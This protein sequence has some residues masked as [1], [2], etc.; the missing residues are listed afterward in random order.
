MPR[1][2]ASKVIE[3]TAAQARKAIAKID[4]QIEELGREIERLARARNAHGALIFTLEGQAALAR[5]RAPLRNLPPP[6]EH[7]EELRRRQD[8]WEERRQREN[9]AETD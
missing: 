9:H 4:S 2:K 5:R 6:I 8:E 3:K 7:F 1:V